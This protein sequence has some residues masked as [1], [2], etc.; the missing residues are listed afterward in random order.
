MES[1][2]CIDASVAIHWIIPTEQSPIVDSL[3]RT[4]DKDGTVLISS[5]VFDA[6]VTSAIR[7]YVYL[8]KLLPEQGEKAYRLYRELGIVI[9]S[10]PGL[11]ETIWNMSEEYNRIRT[12]DMQYVALAELEDCEMWTAD[13]RLFNSLKNR[14]KHI[15]WIGS[16]T[17]S[18][19]KDKKT[20]KLE[21]NTRLDTPGLWRAI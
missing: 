9:V 2:V 20:P 3:L 11:S 4:W 14:N 8:Q 17:E 12:Y 21:K 13:S 18:P 5:P 7:K 19:S 15:R 6:E 1:R 10:P 16:Y